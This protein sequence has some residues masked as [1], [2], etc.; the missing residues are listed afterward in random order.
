MVSGGPVG[1]R[2][3]D[4]H[5]PVHLGSVPSRSGEASQKG[6]LVFASSSV[7]VSIPVNARP[8]VTVLI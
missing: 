3:Q 1:S 5:L 7:L 2:G 6:N 4:I 8:L